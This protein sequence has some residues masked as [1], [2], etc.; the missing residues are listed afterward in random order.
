VSVSVS[1]R[2]AGREG[3]GGREGRDGRGGKGREE[4]GTKGKESRSTHSQPD[5]AM[6]ISRTPSAAGILL[7]AKGAHHDRIVE[8][9][10]RQIGSRQLCVF[11]IR[12]HGPGKIRIR[13]SS[14][15]GPTA[16]AAA[17]MVVVTSPR[18]VQRLHVEDVDALHLAQDLKALEPRGLLEVGRDGPGRGAGWKEV[19][20]G[21]DLW[22]RGRGL[23]VVGAGSSGRLMPRRRAG[24]GE[25]GEGGG[26]LRRGSSSSRAGRV[27]GRWAGLH[28][29]FG[30]EG[31]WVDV[32]WGRG[33][34]KGRGRVAY[35]GRRWT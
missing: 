29:L 15:A 8:R 19:R 25:G 16:E 30:V 20:V 1:E 3:A 17:K 18:R 11:P 31:Q 28:G 6:R 13:T 22:V 5:N 33:G 10:F 9:T 35:G 12:R 23:L 32:V 34:I 2:T 27:S 24:D 7:V 14:G 26:Y 21:F 4:K